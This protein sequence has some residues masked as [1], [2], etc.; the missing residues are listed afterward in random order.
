MPR[1]GTGLVSQKQQSQKAGDFLFEVQPQVI[2]AGETA[3][4]RW[5]I[6]GATKVMLEEA[7]ASKRGLHSM[8]TFGS[9]G[10]LKISPQE[11]TTYVI[12]CEGS[13]T[14]TCLS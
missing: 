12:T 8:G 3:I 6:K 14:Y 2:A 1:S 4:L 7:S 10:T 9:R 5:N 13:T 11:S